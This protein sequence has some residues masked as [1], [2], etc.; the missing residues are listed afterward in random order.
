MIDVNTALAIRLCLLRTLSTQSPTQSFTA[1]SEPPPSFATAQAQ[2]AIGW[3]HTMEGKLS[4]SWC[5]LQA[6][7][8]CS[9]NSPRCAHL[10]HLT[11]TQWCHC[12]AI[13]H[14]RDAHGL[15]LKE[16]QALMAAITDKFDLGLHGLHAQDHH[17]ISRSINYVLS[18]PAAN[19]KAWLSG[20][21]IPCKA[22]LASKARE[23]QASQSVM[24]NWLAQA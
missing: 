20:V 8:Y 3:L 4:R 21:C 19:Q 14:S 16:G 6:D 7:Y 11:H 2:D 22:Y 18:R 5:C 12:N 17:N 23:V 10:L 24:L 9:I 1:L 15:K 13:L